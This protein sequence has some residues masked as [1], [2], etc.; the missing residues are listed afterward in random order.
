M[1]A[2]MAKGAIRRAAARLGYEI[3]RTPPPAAPTGPPAP[4]PH[5]VGSMEEFLRFLRTVGL[6][7]RCVLDVGAYDGRWSAMAAKEFPDARFVLIE[8]QAELA[9]AL[10]AFCAGHRGGARFVSAGAAATA[11]RAVQTTGDELHGSSYLPP[12][13][14]RALQAGRQ[15]V[16]PMVTIDAEFAA[17][18]CLPDLVKLDVQGYELEALKGATRL[19]GHTE[20][21]ILEISMFGGGSSWWPGFHDAVDFMHR[22]NYQVYDVCGFLRRPLDGALGQIDLAFVRADGRLGRDR[23]WSSA[24]PPPDAQK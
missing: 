12:P 21:F 22:R 8:P 14:E 4:P 15:R 20:C 24:E 10:G 16:T 17:E 3:R 9:P 2:T 19:F 6:A 1:L 7:P 18:P 5:G 13:D 23:R 11:G